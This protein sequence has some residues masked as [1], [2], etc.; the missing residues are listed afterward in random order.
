MVCDCLDARVEDGGVVPEGKRGGTEINLD[1]RIPDRKP[2]A[3]GLAAGYGDVKEEGKYL[4]PAEGLGG[5]CGSTLPD[6]DVSNSESFPEI[7]QIGFDA[8]DWDPIRDCR[9][10]I[11]LQRQHRPHMPPIA[12]MRADEQDS[13]PPIQR[14]LEVCL[15]FEIYPF[16]NLFIGQIS[17]PNELGYQT[18]D[19]S[20]VCF[21]KPSNLLFIPTREYPFHI[22]QPASSLGGKSNSDKDPRRLFCALFPDAANN[23]SQ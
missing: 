21:I 10:P 16:P 18:A 3:L 19:V 2:D 9:E 22:P 20:H 5:A 14:F 7:V 13:L 8:S 6:I 11:S 23:P 15:T 12:E 1:G 4:V 17:Q